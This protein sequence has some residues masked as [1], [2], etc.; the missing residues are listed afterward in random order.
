MID[1][2]ELKN[3]TI[4]I[5]AVDVDSKD[6]ENL[7]VYSG[8]INLKDDQLF[9]NRDGNNLFEIS[10]WQ[11]RIK[12]VGDDVKNILLDCNYSLTLSIGDLPE[13]ENPNDYKET[14][15]KWISRNSVEKIKKLLIEIKMPSGKVGKDFLIP[16]FRKSN[17]DFI[18]IRTGRAVSRG[19]I[20][21]IGVEITSEEI[22]IK[23]LKN[24]SLEYEKEKCLNI[25]ND[26]LSKVNQFKIGNVL[27]IGYDSG[28]LKLRKK[29]ER[30]SYKS[31]KL[32]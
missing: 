21:Y 10:D 32:P 27:S 24:N 28:K 9:F 5:I 30:V 13:N 18:N 7:V 31:K 17:N 3:K 8:T 20:V 16:N 25:L 26:Y 2:S 14:G 29:F 1:K 22:L 6:E 12:I 15:L 19:V 11:E 4:A 23:Y